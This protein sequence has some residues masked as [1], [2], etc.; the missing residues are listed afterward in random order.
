[1]TLGGKEVTVFRKGNQVLINGVK[2]TQADNV[3]RNG[4][5]HT[6]NNWLVA[7]VL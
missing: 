3:A 4:V 1:M 6:V 7:P 5:M 2:I